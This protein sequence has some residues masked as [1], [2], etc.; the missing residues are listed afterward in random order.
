MEDSDHWEVR[1]KKCKAYN[2]PSLFLERDFSLQYRQIPR[3]LVFSLREWEKGCL[4]RLRRL[5]FIGQSSKEMKLH[6]NKIPEIWRGLSLYLQLS[7]DHHMW[8]RKLLT[9]GKRTQKI[10]VNKRQSIHGTK[11]SFFPLIGMW[12]LLSQPSVEYSRVLTQ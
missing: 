2:C 9:S 3:N 6:R 11:Y 5:D 10:R 12:N 1:H 7:I 4:E 8:M